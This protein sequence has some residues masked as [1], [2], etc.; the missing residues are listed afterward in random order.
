M[1]PVLA[2][3]ISWMTP[4]L[5]IPEVAKILRCSER[6]VRRRIK[7]GELK[8]LKIGRDYRL[9]SEDLAEFLGR[10]STSDS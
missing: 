2:Q 8:A 4:L 5:T 6:T 1:R 7:A 9:R 10:S 3:G